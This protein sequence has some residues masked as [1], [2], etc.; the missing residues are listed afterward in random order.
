[1]YIDIDKEGFEKLK[2]QGLAASANGDAYE[3]DGAELFADPPYF[4]DGKVHIVGEIRVGQTRLG[5]TVMDI[6]I[7]LDIGSE[8]LNYYVKKIAKLHA[9]FKEVGKE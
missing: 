5:S 4:K 9:A 8:I 6:P 2:K 7:D 1:M 3:Y